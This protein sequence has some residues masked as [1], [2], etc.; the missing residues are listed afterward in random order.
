METVFVDIHN[1][2]PDE[3]KYWRVVD[4]EIRGELRWLRVQSDG[5]WSGVRSQAVVDDANEIE[6]EVRGE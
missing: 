3:Y 6:C 2:F 1:Y 4:N 5:G